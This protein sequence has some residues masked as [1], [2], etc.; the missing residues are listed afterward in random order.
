MRSARRHP[1]IQF[2]GVAGR[3]D[4][5]AIQAFVDQYGIE[6]PTLVDDDGSL[7]RHFG[8]QGQPAW[9]FVS[10]S[11]AVYRTIGA[12]NESELEAV[13]DALTAT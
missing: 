4:P 9:V 10:E 5:G 6:F 12:P 13:L 7:W 1:D 11:G 8:I 2:A 3:D